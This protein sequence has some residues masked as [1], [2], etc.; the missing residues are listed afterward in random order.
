MKIDTH[1]VC[2]AKRKIPEWGGV[3]LKTEGSWGSEGS[4]HTDF[5]SILGGGVSLKTDSSWGSEGFHYI[6]CFQLVSRILNTIPL[7]LSA[8]YI[9]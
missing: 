9:L 8:L 6:N 5:A 2:H 3:S 1:I 4:S 7:L